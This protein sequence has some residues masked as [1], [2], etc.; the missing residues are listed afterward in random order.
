MRNISLIV[1][2][3][4]AACE[5]DSPIAPT[6]VTT[7]TAPLPPPPP[8]NGIPTA[9]IGQSRTEGVAPLRVTFNGSG[10]T[11]PDGDTLSMEWDFGDGTSDTGEVV[12]HKFNDP[13]RYE[14]VLTVSDGR[15][16]S[17]EASVTI[18]V[19]EEEPTPESPGRPS[20]PA[21]A[22]GRYHIEGPWNIDP[23]RF[24]WRGIVR[25]YGY[26]GTAKMV[27]SENGQV[28]AQK[29]GSSRCGETV[30]VELE[31]RAAGSGP[32]IIKVTPP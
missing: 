15:G 27:Y 17:S 13:G 29:Y 24:R 23:A 1:L 11:D 9:V 25:F 7:T 31:G 12:K 10:S 4:L 19:N 32:V 16:G 2:L 5:K 20:G 21:C 22:S 8:A 28:F 3:M 30:S 6:P 14:V 26:A 18:Q